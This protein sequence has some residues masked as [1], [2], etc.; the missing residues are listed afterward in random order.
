MNKWNLPGMADKRL[1]GVKM[2]FS[3]LK[4]VTIYLNVMLFIVILFAGNCHGLDYTVGVGDVLEISVWGEEE[5]TKKLIVRPDG[6]VSYPF[7]GDIVVAS[8]I[9]AEIK[10]ELEE[11]IRQYVPNANV[12]VIVAQLGSMEVYVLGKVARPGA[13]NTS[14]PLTVLQALAMAGGV[15]T[16]ADESGILV[17]RRQ[18]FGTTKLP[19]DYSDVK[20]GK[21]LDQ[22]VVLER[23]DVVLVP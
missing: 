10:A 23:G 6:K 22:N 3:K 5:L 21:G 4:A 16:F 7:I 12:T 17:L 18:E 2:L 13:F 19:F 14:K 8:K 1:M 20:K 9:T 15:T 11:E